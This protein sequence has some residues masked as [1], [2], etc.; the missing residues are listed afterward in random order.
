[1][2]KRIMKEKHY[3]ALSL[4]ILVLDV[5]GKPIEQFPPAGT[6]LFFDSVE[7]HGG[8]C[9]YNTGVDMSRLG[10]KVCVMGLVGDDAFG[11][12]LLDFLKKENVD[13]SGIQKTNKAGTSFSF[14][15]VEGRGQRRIYTSFGASGLLCHNDVC[16]KQID[17]SKLL[18]IGGA[19]M[20]NA[21]DGEG[22]VELLRYARSAGTLTCMDPVYRPETAHLIVQCLPYLDYF[23][24][25]TEESV[26]ITGYSEP[27]DQLRFYLEGGVKIAGIKTGGY[28]CLVSDGKTLWTMGIYDVPVVDTCGAGDAFVGGF[29]YS[30]IKGRSVPECARFASAVA[31]LCVTGIGATAPI[32][33]AREVTAFMDK[34]SLRME[35]SPV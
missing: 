19:C 34:H 15:M 10:L 22:E 27:A 25:N 18:H 24:P 26:H 29:L 11:D 4:G 28:G 16:L 9:A 17:D 2:G 8:G 31:S 7:I 32:P 14:V 6:S 12:L 20:L 21:L 35:E 30:A 13:I 3:D 5:F 23:F 33:H 1:M